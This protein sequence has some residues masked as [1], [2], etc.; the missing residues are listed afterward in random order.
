[1][2]AWFRVSASWAVNAPVA[3]AVT[4]T[5]VVASF[6]KRST[7]ALGSVMPVTLSSDWLVK[8]GGESVGARG[9]KKRSTRPPSVT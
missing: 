1:M 4:V 2:F 7:S 6:R 8:A 5:G 9:A 3:S